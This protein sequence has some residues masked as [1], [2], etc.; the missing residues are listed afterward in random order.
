M[1]NRIKTKIMNKLK[2]FK[3]QLKKNYL[4]QNNKF[5]NNKGSIYPIFLI[6]N[7]HL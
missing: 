7:F 3:F 1:I 6:N 2:K 5:K 4:Y